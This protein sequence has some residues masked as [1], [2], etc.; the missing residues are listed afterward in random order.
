MT[1]DFRRRQNLLRRRLAESNADS[2]VVTHL[3]N[4][5]YMTGF[6]GSAGVVTLKGQRCTLFTDG[7][8]AT[9]APD[10]TK[11]A[12]VK[13]AI[14]K[15]SLLQAAGRDFG[16]SSRSRVVFDPAHTTVAAL[17]ALEAAAGSK[18]SWQAESGW[19]EEL[20][21]VKSADE[22]SRLRAAAKLISRTFE[23]IVG[24]IRP[25]LRERELAAEI[26]YKMKG[27]GAEGPSFDT[28][29]ASGKRSALPHARPTEKRLKRNELVVLDLGAILARYCSDLTRTVYLG[30]APK[31]IKTWYRAVLEAQDAGREALAEG[32]ECGAADSAARSV[33]AR[34]RFADYF[35]HSLGHGLG[36]EI[37]EDPRL[38]A[39]QKRVLQAGNVVTVEP[40]V[41]MEGLGG[42]RI[43]DDVLVK[44]F[45]VEVLTT[46]AREFLEL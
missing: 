37:H 16:G 3:P 17:R 9:Q 2:L 22:I 43:E 41:Y 19:I 44:E 45:G 6:A 20:R 34:Y 42:I 18:V 13:V 26:E 35:T 1:A 33:L 8:Y 24:M 12:G 31:R 46:A 29:V 21:S 40:G 11:A 15:G 30:R 7:R 4:I 23:S 28:I 10:E 27:L 38:A 25:G 39:G 5:F 14:A 36:L 32:V